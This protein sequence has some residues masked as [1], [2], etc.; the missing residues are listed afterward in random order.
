VRKSVSG[1]RAQWELSSPPARRPMFLGPLRGVRGEAKKVSADVGPRRPKNKGGK[2][3]LTGG[4]QQRRGRQRWPGSCSRIGTLGRNDPCGAQGRDSERRGGR[5]QFLRINRAGRLGGRFIG[6]RAPGRQH[7]AVRPGRS[8]AAR[9]WSAAEKKKREK[10]PRFAGLA[11]TVL[12]ERWAHGRW[13]MVGRIFSFFFRRTGYLFGSTSIV[14]RA[15]APPCVRDPRGRQGAARHRLP[16][17]AGI[18]RMASAQRAGRHGGFNDKPC[19]RAGAY[20]ARKVSI[21][22]TLA[23]MVASASPGGF[24]LRPGTARHRPRS[25]RQLSRP[26]TPV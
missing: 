12:M 20:R 2:A 19:R 26:H 22:H 21:F 16:G 6:P 18:E 4:G 5:S 11:R 10:S 23:G 9:A 24:Q 3:I 13:R 7:G 15:A 1:R 17:S 25:Q 14:G 8:S